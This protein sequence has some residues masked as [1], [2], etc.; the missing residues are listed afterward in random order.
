MKKFR[1]GLID[2]DAFWYDQ[3]CGLTMNPMK[4]TSG[5]TYYIKNNDGVLFAVKYGIN[6]NI[7]FNEVDE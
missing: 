7:S 2:E 6:G 4:M 3:S 1:H 5:T